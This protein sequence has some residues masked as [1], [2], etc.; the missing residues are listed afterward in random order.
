MSYLWASDIIYSD[1][2]DSFISEIL[3]Y[4]S[5]ILVSWCK[6]SWTV[7]FTPPNILSGCVLVVSMLYL[8]LYIEVLVMNKYYIHLLRTFCIDA[9]FGRSV[10]FSAFS[11][12]I[13]RSGFFSRERCHSLNGPCHSSLDRSV[14][15][16]TFSLNILRSWFFSRNRCHSTMPPEFGPIS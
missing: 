8:I 3:K 10:Y 13:L 11:L 7:R 16:S 12:N 14:D 5:R 6:R 2:I 9:M 15:F 4:K 1:V